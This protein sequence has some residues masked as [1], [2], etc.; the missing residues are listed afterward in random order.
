TDELRVLLLV[1]RELRQE[2]RR[3]G[4]RDRAEVLDRLVASHADA[5]VRNRDSVL[6][7]VR[8]DRDRELAAALQQ[9]GLRQRFETELVASIRGVR[10]ELSKKDFLVAVKRMDH[11]LEQ[12]LD[13]RL[14][15]HGLGDARLAHYSRTP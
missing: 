8:I 1:A 7:L 5:V 9:L 12:L 6:F 2:L 10:N 15:S 11:Q 4:L 13:L 3:A 14:E